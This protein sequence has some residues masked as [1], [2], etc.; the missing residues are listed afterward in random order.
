M[1]THKHPNP[2]LKMIYYIDINEFYKN[3]THYNYTYYLV[4]VVVLG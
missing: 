2:K 4:I 3:Y 1:K